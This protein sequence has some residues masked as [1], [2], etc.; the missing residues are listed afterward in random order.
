MYIWGVVGKLDWLVGVP[1][2][3]PKWVAEEITNAKWE[4]LDSF[5]ASGY[6]LDVN[7]KDKTADVQLYDPS[8]EGRYILNVDVPG[9]ITIDALKRGEVYSFE[10]KTFKSVL[11]DKVKK[12]LA[13]EYQVTME[14]IFRYEIVTAELLEDVAQPAAA[15]QESNADEE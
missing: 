3:L 9:S 14:D 6:F 13:E 10:V 11:S 2:K 1:E 7:S 4:A 5:K 12:F 8:P 15:A